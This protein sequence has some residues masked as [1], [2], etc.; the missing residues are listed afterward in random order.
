MSNVKKKETGTAVD[1]RSEK[2]KYHHNKKCTVNDDDGASLRMAYSKRERPSNKRVQEVLETGENDDGTKVHLEPVAIRIFA[3]ETERFWFVM[4][5]EGSDVST[6]HRKCPQGSCAGVASSMRYDKHMGH[7]ELVSVAM[8]CECVKTMAKICGAIA[9][10][11]EC[12]LYTI[13]CME[14]I[15]NY[16]CKSQSRA[17]TDTAF[18][19]HP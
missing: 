6:P 17:L 14:E 15:R 11:V 18:C 3:L 12:H 9:L 2:N 4:D 16:K 13:V 8:K 10:W 7:Y 19:R 1:D 5:N